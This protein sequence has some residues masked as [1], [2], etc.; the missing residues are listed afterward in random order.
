MSRFSAPIM[1]GKSVSMRYGQHGIKE[2]LLVCSTCHRL[3]EPPRVVLFTVCVTLPATQHKFMPP[4]AR[5]RA[6]KYLHQHFELG[7]LLQV[8]AAGGH[9][10]RT[11]MHICNSVELVNLLALGWVTVFRAGKL[12]SSWL[13]KFWAGGLHGL[14]DHQRP[15]VRAE[16]R[17]QGRQPS[18]AAAVLE[19]RGA[20]RQTRDR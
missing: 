20:R 17:G 13:V 1:W 18:G 2:M 4:G 8:R 11:I 14:H 6:T 3:S 9:A 12:Q 5:C 10:G 15:A 16:V 19:G 7:I